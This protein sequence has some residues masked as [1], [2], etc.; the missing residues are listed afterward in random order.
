MPI[1][2]WPGGRHGDHLHRWFQMTHV[3]IGGIESPPC[4]NLYDCVDLDLG[5]GPNEVVDAE[6]RASEVR[7]FAQVGGRSRSTVSSSSTRRALPVRH[8]P[9]ERTYHCWYGARKCFS[10]EILA[11]LK[12]LVHIRE[13]WI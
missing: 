7:E 8:V 4:G 11:N 9:E 2:A 10:A 6:T 5:L 1:Q 3:S 12:L 13:R